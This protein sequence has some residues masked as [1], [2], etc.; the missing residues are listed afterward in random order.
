MSQMIPW[1]LGISHG[2]LYNEYESEIYSVVTRVRQHGNVKN[3]P[4]SSKVV[5]GEKNCPG[6]GSTLVIDFVM[7]IMI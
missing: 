4:T 5:Q 3:Q 2:T 7:I 1:G 6:F